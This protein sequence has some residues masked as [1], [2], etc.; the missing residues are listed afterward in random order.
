MP[1]VIPCLVT[2]SLG[3]GTGKSIGR[4][5]SGVGKWPLGQPRDNAT[6]ISLAVTLRISYFPL[7]EDITM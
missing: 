7:P 1:E 4:P 6:L 3:G 5:I 2:A